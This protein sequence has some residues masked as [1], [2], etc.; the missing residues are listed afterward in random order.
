MLA[1]LRI[2]SGDIIARAVKKMTAYSLRLDVAIEVNRHFL[3]NEY[4]D[5]S[6]C[7]SVLCSELSNKFLYV[8]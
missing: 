2:I 7:F 5:L 3:E 1:V 6:F 8:K 4:G